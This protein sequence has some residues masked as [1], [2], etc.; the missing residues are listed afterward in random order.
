MS[1]VDMARGHDDA[2][3]ADDAPLGCEE[4]ELYAG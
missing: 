1:H 2:C 4:P 3:V